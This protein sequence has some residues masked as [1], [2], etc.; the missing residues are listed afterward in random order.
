[1]TAD[2]TA[3]T[4][5]NRPEIVVT[6]RPTHHHTT[7][8]RRTRMYDVIVVGA[9]CA[10]SPTAMLLAR[11]GYRVLLLDRAAFP[12]DSIRNHLI[13]PSGSVQL[14]RWGL[15]PTV[16]ASNCPPIRTFTTDFGDFPLCQPIEEGDGVDATYAPRRIVLDK[17]L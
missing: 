1:M 15:L 9:R 12:S 6:N 16:I 5:T 17:I 8:Q 2:K 10:G 4:G 7:T 11:K 3:Y 14:H 13:Q